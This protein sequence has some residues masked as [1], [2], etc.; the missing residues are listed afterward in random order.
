M[1]SHDFAE[2]Y[3]VLPAL[4]NDSLAFPTFSSGPTQLTEISVP[5]AIDLDDMLD[6]VSAHPVPRDVQDAI[7]FK[8][9]LLYIYTSGT[10]GLP[11][12]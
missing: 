7:S 1:S 12:V 9:K 2:V 8:D 3:E 11:K 10:T 6:T 5:G 4:K